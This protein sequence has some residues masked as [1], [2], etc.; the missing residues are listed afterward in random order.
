MVRAAIKLTGLLGLLAVFSVLGTGIKWL[1]RDER[2]R[3]RRAARLV[4]V[5]C[6]RFGLPLLGIEVEIDGPGKKALTSRG[7]KLFIS[8]HLSYVDV[9]IISAYF[10]N[11]FVT[12]QEIRNSFPLGWWADLGGSFF[13]ERRNRNR[14]QQEVEDIKNVL[15]SGFSVTIFPEAT[16]TN[17]DFVKPFKNSLFA[18]AIDSGTPVLPA[19][20]VYKTANGCAID[21]STRDAIFW[22]GDMEF[23]P[24]LWK[25][26]SLS[27]V[28][29]TLNILEPIPMKEGQCRKS[30]AEQSHF[31][32]SQCYTQQ[33]PIKPLSLIP[34]GT[35]SESLSEN[36][37]LRSTQQGATTF[38]IVQT[39]S[40]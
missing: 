23:A 15:A 29:M 36:I 32:I 26:L 30:L 34:M 27:R 4:S 40:T 9:L 17:G 6:R 22:Y 13:V 39:P 11:T 1:T 2:L 7:A 33:T 20:V 5:L 24:H 25:L 31:L 12:S 35:P 21:E 10:P 14:I 38:T 18:A 3:K 28:T 37:E 16:S 19:A 8:N